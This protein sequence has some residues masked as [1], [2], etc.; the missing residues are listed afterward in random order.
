M[1][2]GVAFD[3]VLYALRI[4][5]SFYTVKYKYIK[6]RCGVLCICVCFKFLEVCFLH[7]NKHKNGKVLFFSETQCR[8]VQILTDS[9]CV[10]YL[11]YRSL[12]VCAET[13]F[14]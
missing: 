13:V 8:C 2:F 3:A 9:L 11:M 12:L 1:K 6:V 4:V 7:I 14:Y 5:G 10:R